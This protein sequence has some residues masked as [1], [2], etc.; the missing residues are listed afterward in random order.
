[1]DFKRRPP[2]LLL[3]GCYCLV[4][5]S[6]TPLR[7]FSP[8]FECCCITRTFTVAIWS[9]SIAVR[10]CCPSCTTPSQ[11]LKALVFPILAA[12]HEQQPFPFSR[13]RIRDKNKIPFRGNAFLMEKDVV[14]FSVDHCDFRR[15]TR[16][17]R[18]CGYRSINLGR[19]IP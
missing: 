2:L 6:T 13:N 4:V 17:W 14:L 5:I 9:G 8:Y 3:G 16:V 7:P 12:L 10:A 1:M 11:Q 18:R 19:R 15:Y